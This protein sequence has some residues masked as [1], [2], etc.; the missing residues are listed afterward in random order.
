LVIEVY[1]L[2]V[3]TVADF[4]PVT[5]A[6]ATK[7]KNIYIIGLNCC[8]LEHVNG[9]N[10]CNVQWNRIYHFNELTASGILPWSFPSLLNVS[11]LNPY[12]IALDYK[13]YQ[14]NWRTQ[15]LLFL[16]LSP[17]SSLVASCT[18]C[19]IPPTKKIIALRC[20][21]ISC[22][23]FQDWVKTTELSILI[24]SWYGTN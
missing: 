14:Q 17:L 20:P 7:P 4:R 21:S 13:L 19:P 15:E 9:L 2:E 3:H 5:A 8:N 11:P 16:Y 23:F 1:A 22:K 6:W 18:A 24:L 12:I 10:G